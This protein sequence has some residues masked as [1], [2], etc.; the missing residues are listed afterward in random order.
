MFKAKSLMNVG[1]RSV[2]AYPHC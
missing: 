1:T 2:V